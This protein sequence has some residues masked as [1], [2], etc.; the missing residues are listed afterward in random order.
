MGH[1]SVVAVAR[2]GKDFHLVGFVDDLVVIPVLLE[3][4]AFQ[5]LVLDHELRRGLCDL[6]ILPR[7]EEQGFDP[8]VLVR[9]E[10]E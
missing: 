9:R 3:L 1:S 5:L 4:E 7:R 2:V 6:I 8:A 10:I